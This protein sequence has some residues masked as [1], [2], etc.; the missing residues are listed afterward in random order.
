MMWHNK[1]VW[2]WGL[3]AAGAVLAGCTDY[4]D[5][6]D[7]S[8][9]PPFIDTA[10]IS[11]EANTPAGLTTDAG[12]DYQA[13]LIYEVALNMRGYDAVDRTPIDQDSVADCAQGGT[14]IHEHFDADPDS[15][16]VDGDLPISRVETVHCVRELDSDPDVTY[17]ADGLLT[18]SDTETGD[19][20]AAPCPV[21]YGRF[22][23][24]LHPYRVEYADPAGEPDRTRSRVE[25]DG[26]YHDGPGESVSDGGGGTLPVAERT[27]RL[28]VVN[29][30]ETLVADEVT[31][32]TVFGLVY[33]DSSEGGPDG[34]F[35]RR[36]VPDTAELFLD[37]PLA[38]GSDGG[39]EC[40][41]GALTVTTDTRMALDGA[42][43]ITAGEVELD[44]GDGDT[45]TLEFVNSSGDVFVTGS[46]GNTQT[47]TRA[48]I[49]DLRDTCFQ[50]VPARR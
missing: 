31:G 12:L 47:Y 15:P 17:Y 23:G 33:G 19:C 10:A 43:N 46:G 11:E 9:N 36:D 40:V 41:G 5:N 26:R 7:D 3:L 39:A 49:Q 48:D 29:S 50:T 1:D 42:G 38:S 13:A 34:R 35:V 4:S 16:Y 18:Y 6:V 20:D 27:Q 32:K 44:N 45:A 14:L 8:A 28:T 2:L 22:G 25:V 37:G 21:A 30:V 24:L